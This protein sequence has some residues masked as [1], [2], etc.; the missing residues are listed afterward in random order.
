[1]FMSWLSQFFHRKKEENK[2]TYTFS[3]ADRVAAAEKRRMA[4]L[5]KKQ[6]DIM[7]EELEHLQQMQR[8]EQ[9]RE[10]IDSFKE[11]FDRDRDDEPDDYEDDVPDE[12]EELAKGALA[13]FI[14]KAQAKPEQQQAQQAIKP[15]TLSDVQIQNFLKSIPSKYLKIAKKMEDEELRTA[16][17]S[18]APNIDSDSIQRTITQIRAHA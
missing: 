9:M 12:I 1:M 7:A 11:Y 10:K 14:Q 16:I 18:Y 2:P 13:T 17:I 5:M 4:A 8:Q 15:A 3:D 6:N